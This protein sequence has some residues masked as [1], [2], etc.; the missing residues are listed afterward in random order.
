LRSR[1]CFPAVA[2]LPLRTLLAPLLLALP[3]PFPLLPILR[4]GFPLLPILRCHSRRCL[5]R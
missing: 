5:S 3:V 1:R 4:C 2:L